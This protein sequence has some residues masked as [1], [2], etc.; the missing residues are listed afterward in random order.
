M[1]AMANDMEPLLSAYHFNYTQRPRRDKAW[2]LAYYLL[3]LL[4]LGWALI[5]VVLRPLVRSLLTLRPELLAIF[6]TTDYLNNPNLCPMEVTAQNPAQSTGAGA[7]IIRAGAKAHAVIA[8]MLRRRTTAEWA[9]TARLGDVAVGAP[10]DQYGH[11]DEVI[12]RNTLGPQRMRPSSSQQSERPVGNLH[13]LQ[14]IIRRLELPKE[15]SSDLHLEEGVHLH[16]YTD[17]SFRALDDSDT[18]DLNP[19]SYLDSDDVPQSRVDLTAMEGS[20]AS[21]DGLVPRALLSFGGLLLLISLGA[22]VV[23][24]FLFLLA[25][26][27]SPWALVLLACGLQ[28]GAALASAVVAVKAGN[29]GLALMLLLVAAAIA[30]SL[31]CGREALG[32]VSR[33]LGLAAVV[34]RD[35]PLLLGLV[36]ILKMALAGA[37][38][39][40]LVAAAVV[41]VAKD[42]VPNP[43]RAGN[44][45]CMTPAGQQVMCCS[46]A[47]SAALPAYLPAVTITLAWT[48]LLLFELK[49]YVVSGVV[50]QWYFSPA[51]HLVSGGYYPAGEVGGGHGGGGG[52]MYGADDVREGGIAGDI[53]AVGSGCVVLRGCAGFSSSRALVASLCHALGP[54]FGSLCAASGVL[55]TTAYL[56]AIV[57]GTMAGSRRSSA[58]KFGPDACCYNGLHGCAV[59]LRSFCCSCVM[60]VLE[61]LTKFATVQM[62]MSGLGF[63]RASQ[64]AVALLR[65]NFMDAYSM[66]W[67]M[68]MVLHCGAAAFAATWGYVAYW[69]LARQ[70]WPAQLTPSAPLSASA[71]ATLGALAAATAELVLSFV[72]SVLVNISDALFICFVL[73]RDSAAVTWR[74]LHGVFGSLP[75]CTAARA[76]AEAHNSMHPQYYHHCGST[77]GYGHHNATPSPPAHYYVPPPASTYGGP[78]AT[79]SY[80]VPPESI[81]AGLMQLGHTI[82][83]GQRYNRAQ[84]SGGH[85]RVGGFWGWL[86]SP[87]GSGSGLYG[88]PVGGSRYDRPQYPPPAV[89]SPPYSDQRFS[90]LSPSQL[91]PLPAP[92]YFGSPHP[93]AWP[94]RR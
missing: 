21:D 12:V 74:D 42:L 94:T 33:L 66:W 1:P 59:G 68:P 53:G 77:G 64:E 80:Q 46:L 65:R 13:D 90:M 22:A 49:V 27:H 30:V 26:R 45:D 87:S 36:V 60:T 56:R 61:Q 7:L 76:A 10:D 15:T 72:C 58:L 84:Y 75:C 29:S 91:G 17:L 34:L 51:G 41:L 16:S 23:L 85:G 52:G 92:P 57:N 32:L 82:G 70:C 48:L 44:T 35:N 14:T 3:L 39:L 81:G 79:Y 38:V 19:D 20:S 69:L 93:S 47:P 5:S 24:A 25:L 9:S 78:Y 54:S 6:S 40:L 28:V 67:Y 2:A 86:R 88:M 71:A 11:P 31:Y 83:Y 18:N 89:L 4:T 50:A 63:W 73:D 43:L 37:T 8:P 55:G 62:S